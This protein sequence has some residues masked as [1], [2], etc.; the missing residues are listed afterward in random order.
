MVELA[1]ATSNRS[2]GQAGSEQQFDADPTYYGTMCATS[3]ADMDANDTCFIQFYQANG[4][5]QLRMGAFGGGHF[6]GCLVA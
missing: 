4:D 6:G 2:Y 5:N 1:I 3:C